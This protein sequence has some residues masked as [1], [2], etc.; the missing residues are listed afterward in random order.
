[1]TDTGIP[2]P[3]RIDLHKKIRE[4]AKLSCKEE[5]TGYITRDEMIELIV[6]LKSVEQIINESK[7]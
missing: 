5:P 6:I 7:R 1:M 3:D 2:K 4:M